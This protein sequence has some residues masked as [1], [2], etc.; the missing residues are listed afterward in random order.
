MEL[1]CWGPSRVQQLYPG[2]AQ[3][4]GGESQGCSQSAPNDPRSTLRAC[5]AALLPLTAQDNVHAPGR[6][7]HRVLG[8]A[9]RI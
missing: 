4:S 2:K 3:L 9:R 1:L 8:R 5:I 7:H 6:R